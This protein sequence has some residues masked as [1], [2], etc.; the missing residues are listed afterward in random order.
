L[1]HG[2]WEEKQIVSEAWV[3]DSTTPKTKITGLD[4]GYLWWNIPLST[5]EKT[6]K[7][8]TATGNGGQYVMV[9]PE[10]NMIAVFTGG[11]YNSQDDKLPFA[12]MQRV[13]LPLLNTAL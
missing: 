3:A 9:I 13:L 7:A 1:N 8:I 6:V 4:Y 12:I 10:M 5:G 2:I 11:A